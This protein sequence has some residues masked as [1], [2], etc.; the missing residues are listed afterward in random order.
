MKLRGKLRI[1]IKRHLQNYRLYI[2][3]REIKWILEKHLKRV[4]DLDEKV[5]SLRPEG[6]SRG[7]VLVSYISDGFFLKPGQAIPHTHTNYWETLQIAQTFVGLGYSVDAVSRLS[8]TF[9]PQ[10]DYSFFTG[11]RWGVHKV[12]PLLNKDCVKILLVDGAH[13]VFNNSAQLGRIRALQERR[14]ISLIP[15]PVR[16]NLAIEYADCATVLGNEFTLSTYRYAN[17][18]MYLVPIS[19]PA[20]YPWPGDKDFEACRRRFLWFGSATGGLVH[21]G[22]DLVLETFAEMPG[23]DLTVCG[24]IEEDQD[25]VDVYSKELYHTPNIHVLGWVDVCSPEFVQIADSCIGLIYP[26][27]SEGQSGSVVT[28]MHAGLIPIISY[29]SGVD[30]RDCGVILENCCLEEIRQ[31]IET[32]SSLP[33]EELKRRAGKAWQYARGNHTRERFAEEYRKIAATIIDMYTR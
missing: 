26:S 24:P 10:K 23:Y 22:L 17:K 21:K 5:V 6:P 14:G 29:E 19:S 2:L 13:W 3:A 20:V 4:N 31:S 28:C 30:V 15:I 18:P 16:P 27:C 7:N 8:N 11:V 12:A 1:R 32:V 9:V 33:V 25:F